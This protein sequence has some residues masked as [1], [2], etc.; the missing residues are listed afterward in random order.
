[1]NKELLGSLVNQVI[2]VDRGGPE[3]NIGML[4]GA[5]EDHIT[6]LTENDGIIYY[7]TQHIKSLTHDSKGGLEFNTVI[8]ENFEYVKGEDFKSVLGSLRYQWVQINRGG[9]E[10][11][12]GVLDSVTDDYL[13]IILNEEVI[14]VSTFHIRSISY[15]LKIEKEAAED[16]TEK[17]SNEKKQ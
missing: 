17:E 13:T 4:L 11:L 1:M 6:I 5:G 15:G 8:P 3:N 2:K 9:P 16:V 10:K 12:E 14:R 7:K